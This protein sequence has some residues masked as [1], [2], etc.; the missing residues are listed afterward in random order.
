MGESSSMSS[1]CRRCFSQRCLTVRWRLA[2][3]CW[4][5]KRFPWGV[6][7]KR[8]RQ[9]EKRTISYFSES[10]H[11]GSVDQYSHFSESASLHRCGDIF[12]WLLAGNQSSPWRQQNK[13]TKH[14]PE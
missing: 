1:C 8:R 10:V 3:A 13:P 2:A 11:E 6:A 14:L 5:R 7:A 9:R 4:H 12:D